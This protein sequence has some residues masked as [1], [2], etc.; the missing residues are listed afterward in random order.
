MLQ[1]KYY[2]N[3]CQ[4]NWYTKGNGNSNKENYKTC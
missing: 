2:S 4:F 1:T 3:K